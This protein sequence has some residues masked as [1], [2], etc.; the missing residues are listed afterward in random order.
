MEERP[1]LTENERLAYRLAG[2]TTTR[3]MTL[4]GKT[5]DDVIEER[6]T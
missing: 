2:D 6:K 1:I 5:A 4:D 3:V